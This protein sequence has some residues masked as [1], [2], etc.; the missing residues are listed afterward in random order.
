MHLLAQ[1]GLAGAVLALM[2]TCATLYVR[3]EI[4]NRTALQSFHTAF[5]KSYLE[6]CSAIFICALLS[7]HSCVELYSAVIFPVQS[8]SPGGE[9]S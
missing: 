4:K 2:S 5:G 8:S 9:L 1:H 6:M 3:D 7:T